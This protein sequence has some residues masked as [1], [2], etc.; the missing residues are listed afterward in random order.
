M[1]NSPVSFLLLCD[2]GG[3]NC[4]FHL[5]KAPVAKLPL[6]IKT[7]YFPDIPNDSASP[8]DSA[9]A[10]RSII[11]NPNL[12]N[13]SWT[14][15]EQNLE[16][17]HSETFSSQSLISL[18]SAFEKF[19][20]SVPKT[21]TIAKQ[22][23]IVFLSIC[24]PV[25]NQ[26]VHSMANLGWTDVSAVSLKRMGFKDVFLS[27]D[28]EALG[29]GL[30]RAS[31]IDQLK[32]LFMSTDL[33]TTEGV[34]SSDAKEFGALEWEQP[35]KAEFDFDKFATKKNKKILIVGIG[36]GVGT[37][38]IHNYVNFKGTRSF[39]EI[40]PSEAGHCFFGFKNARDI[41]LV[42]YIAK[43]RYKNLSEDYLPFEYLV[44]GMS[45]PLIYSFLSENRALCNF[46]SKQI[47]ERCLDSTDAVA[48][49][50]IEYYLDLLGQFV[51]QVAICFLPEV[52][53]L[54]GPLLASLRN[55]LEK[56]P[57]LKWAFWRSLLAKSHMSP[58]YQNL[59]VFTLHEKFNLSA[60]G[61]VIMFAEKFGE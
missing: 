6:S 19:F 44:S 61:S 35:P 45:I 25:E 30:A 5:N 29:Y 41:E 47:F 58:V 13:E 32:P 16:N 49:E 15:N 10:K 8:G 3:T 23:I 43:V 31:T 17:L 20:D 24:G 40:L 4:R 34:L 18:A 12:P 46:S 54:R 28:F 14:F 7:F 60:L 33:L 21:L 55:L 52:V 56:Q 27:N 2:I 11:F 1:E 59:S 53:I 51:H 57:Q 22:D 48:L 50:T 9:P 42:R 36:T 38:M 39:L 37:T 26:S